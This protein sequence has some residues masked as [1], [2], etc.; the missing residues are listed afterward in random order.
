MTDAEQR[1]RERIDRGIRV[2]SS[3]VFALSSWRE[4]A[5]LAAPRVLPVALCMALPL[6]VTPAV[7]PPLPVMEPT[8]KPSDSAKVTKPLALLAAKVLTLLV[9]VGREIAPPRWPNKF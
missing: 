9:V 3:D 5:Y 7:A 6:V 8:T 4:M 1:R 2:R